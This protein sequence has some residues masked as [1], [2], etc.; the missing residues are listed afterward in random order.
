MLPQLREMQNTKVWPRLSEGNTCSPANFFEGCID[1]TDMELMVGMVTVLWTLPRNNPSWLD[2]YWVLGCQNDAW[3]TISSWHGIT[4]GETNKWSPW[5]KDLLRGLDD[6]LEPFSKL[7]GRCSWLGDDTMESIINKNRGA[8]KQIRGRIWLW[9]LLSF[10]LEW[11]LFFWLLMPYWLFT[12]RWWPA[13]SFDLH[14]L[15]PLY[16]SRQEGQSMDR[17]LQWVLAPVWLPLEAWDIYR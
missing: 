16:R 3:R 8:N 12:R 10:D 4:R 14:C 17:R 5:W 11:V 13:P 15:I 2:N 6:I 9:L 7:Q 1:F